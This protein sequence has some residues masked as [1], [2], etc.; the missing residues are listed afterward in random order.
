MIETAALTVSDKLMA[1]I[2]YFVDI[3]KINILR[4]V[5]GKEATCS[6]TK[7]KNTQARQLFKTETTDDLFRYYPIFPT[8]L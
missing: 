4:L 5:C 6:G 8:R 1:I 3:K 7:N 2:E